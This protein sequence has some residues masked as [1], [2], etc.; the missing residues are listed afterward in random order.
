MDEAITISKLGKRGSSLT[1]D[2]V[3]AKHAGIYKCF[4]QNQAGSAD[5]LSELIVNG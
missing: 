2:N 5:F 3:S 4:A 1:I